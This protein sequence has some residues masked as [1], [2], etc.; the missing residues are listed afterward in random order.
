MPLYFSAFNDKVYDEFG[1][2][3]EVDGEEGALENS[4]GSWAYYTPLDGSLMQQSLD[5][6]LENDKRLN[7]AIPNTI[8]HSGYYGSD[9][10]DVVA[11]AVKWDNYGNDGYAQVMLECSGSNGADSAWIGYTVPTPKNHNNDGSWTNKERGTLAVNSAGMYWSN[12]IPQVSQFYQV[13]NQLPSSETN[14]KKWMSDGYTTIIPELKFPGPHGYSEMSACSAYGKI[15]GN[16]LFGKKQ[17]EGENFTEG[18]IVVR[19]GETPIQSVFIA[20]DC[21]NIPLNIDA[22]IPNNVTSGDL[23]V[24]YYTGVAYNNSWAKADGYSKDSKDF[25]L[26]P[27]SSGVLVTNY[28]P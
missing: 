25:K 17:V 16:F 10:T 2:P 13:T 28:I 23:N 15:Q 12:A 21:V 22:V 9:A 3:R 7:A 1:Q 11:S 8:L 24:T 4:P 26:I 20:K 6:L 14:Y 19:I 27:I 5:A 18:T